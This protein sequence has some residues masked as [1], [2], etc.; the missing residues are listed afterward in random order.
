MENKKIFNISIA[1]CFLSLLLMIVIE[2]FPSGIIKCNFISGHRGFFE[3]VAIGIF[4]GMLV[5]V[6]SSRIMYKK[7]MNDLAVKLSGHLMYM[8]FY[9]SHLISKVDYTKVDSEITLDHEID[10][11]LGIYD[12][13]IF[14]CDELRRNLELQFIFKSNMELYNK[15]IK[16][17]TNLRQYCASISRNMRYAINNNHKRSLLVGR[18]I[19]VE[20]FLKQVKE[21][22][23]EFGKMG[24]LKG[25][26]LKE[27]ESAVDKFIVKND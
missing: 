21:L 1:G 2:Y 26:K 5:T 15:I 20:F 7:Y 16:E 10:F 17:I 4:T 13:I 18:D 9:L 22:L 8:R 24:N 25:K 12:K 27:Y 14:E 6:V 11:S 23:M 3:S 19:K